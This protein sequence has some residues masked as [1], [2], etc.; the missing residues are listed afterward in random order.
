MGN[1]SKVLSKE[2]LKLIGGLNEGN[3]VRL[4]QNNYGNKEDILGK[5]IGK[6]RLSNYS[7]SRDIILIAGF[8]VGE[9]KLNVYKVEVRSIL[10]IKRSRITGK[11]GEVVG[12]YFKKALA[13]YKKEQAFKELKEKQEAELK[14]LK[15]DRTKVA[16]KNKKLLEEDNESEIRDA[17]KVMKVLSK[18]VGKYGGSVHVRDNQYT[19][20]YYEKDNGIVFNISSLS[21]SRGLGYYTSLENHYVDHEYDGEQYVRHQEDDKTCCY[22]DIC[23][24]WFTPKEIN[25][26]GY[27]KYADSKISSYVGVRKGEMYFELDYNVE[28][29]GNKL[30]KE[31]TKAL[32]IKIYKTVFQQLNV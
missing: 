24:Y 10:N 30:S 8:V 27:K 11:S 32:A 1:E 7:G 29:K 22:K 17:L 13:Y 3:T 25:M 12:E 16:E 15:E 23:K 28:F 6:D 18:L 5:V 21:A 2:E 4:I 26:K 14:K 9:F 19:V 20:S 31:E